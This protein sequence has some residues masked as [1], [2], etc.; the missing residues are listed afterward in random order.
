MNKK[1]SKLETSLGDDTVTVEYFY[2]PGR[3]AV[4]TLRNGDPGY[5]ED[6][7]QVEIL[8]VTGPHGEIELTDHIEN[9]L[10]E[11][12]ALHEY[13]LDCERKA[14]AAEFRA[15]LRRDDQKTEVV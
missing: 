4:M 5:P 10:W 13:D 2:S 14:E 8:T 1:P 7:A 3:P 12:V 6:P 15:K 9:S 11:T